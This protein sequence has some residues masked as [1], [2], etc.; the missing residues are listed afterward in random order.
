MGSINPVFLLPEKLKTAAGDI[1][2]M[3]AT[4]VTLVVGQFCTNPGIGF[5]SEGEDLQ[6][7]IS[8]VGE[9]IKGVSPAKMLHAGIAKAYAEKEQKPWRRKN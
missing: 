4:S 8:V 6:Q 5:G 9:E 3:Y 2:K 7:F 1:A